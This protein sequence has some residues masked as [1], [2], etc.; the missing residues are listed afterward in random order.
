MI[1]VSNFHIETFYKKY[2]VQPF[3]KACARNTRERGWEPPHLT[4]GI[5]HKIRK[6]YPLNTIYLS[7]TITTF[8]SIM[9][10]ILVFFT[11]HQFYLGILGMLLGML[12]WDGWSRTEGLIIQR[13]SQCNYT[14]FSCKIILQTSNFTIT[15]KFSYTHKLLTFPLHRFN[16]NQTFDFVVN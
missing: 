4:S 2:T 12:L 15:S 3:K 1:F 5:A 10:D 6:F 13:A 7:I 14:V 11:L 9:R 8:F 16:F